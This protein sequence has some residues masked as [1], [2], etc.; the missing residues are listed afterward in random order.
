MSEGIRYNDRALVLGQ[1]GSG[2]SE[3][4]N[5]QFSAIRC[6]KLL[7]DTKEEWTIPGLEQTSAVE[8]IDWSAP[9]IHY[10]PATSR[11]EEIDELFQVCYG[12]RHLVVCVHELADLCEYEASRTPQFVKDY[13]SKGRAHGLGLLGASQRPFEMPKR[14]KTEAQHVFVVVPR[15][16][17]DDHNTIARLAGRPP[18]ELADLIDQVLASHGRHSFL[19]FDRV[20]QTMVVCPPLPEHVRSQSIVRRRAGVV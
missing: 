18:R 5:H 17:E 14:A 4:L 3:L 13:Y 12:R 1:T 2:K 10:V 6:Q 19:W 16:D 9:V 15:L 7:L 11:R 8:A 20:Q